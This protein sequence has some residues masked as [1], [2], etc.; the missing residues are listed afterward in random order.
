MEGGAVGVHTLRVVWEAWSADGGRQMTL[1]A[2][3]GQGGHFT[4]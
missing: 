4:A 3:L 1:D 2:S